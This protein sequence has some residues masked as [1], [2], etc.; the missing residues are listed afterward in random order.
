MGPRAKVAIGLGPAQV[1]TT[2]P[3]SK[4]WRLPCSAGMDAVYD[5]FAC[6]DQIV[7]GAVERENLPTPCCRITATCRVSR[8]ERAGAASRIS[9]ASFTLSNV[10]GNTS[11]TVPMT[12]SKAG[13]IASS[14]LDRHLPVQDLLQH[15]GV[16]REPPIVQRKPFQ[17]SPRVRLVRVVGGDEVRRNV[18]VAPDHDP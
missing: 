9:R 4:A 2:K 16:A 8:A 11:S 1:S 17:Q 12:A 15:L 5:R 18:R 6:R 3:E 14:W 7:E 13:W 10:T